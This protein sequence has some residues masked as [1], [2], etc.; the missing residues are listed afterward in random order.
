MGKGGAGSR[1]KIPKCYVYIIYLQ[2]QKN[3]TMQFIIHKPLHC[4]L[5]TA[6]SIVDTVPCNFET[7]SQVCHTHNL[8][9]FSDRNNSG[10]LEIQFEIYLKV[11]MTTLKHLVTLRSHQLVFIL[12]LQKHSTQIL[13]YFLFSVRQKYHNHHSQDSASHLREKHEK[14]LHEQVKRIM[15]NSSNSV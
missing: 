6:S 2:L 3:L 9:N 11:R 14:L 5:V 4:Y 8:P 13:S 12:G 10:G 7:I 15:R 1:L